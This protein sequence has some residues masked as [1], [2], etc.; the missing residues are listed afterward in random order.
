MTGHAPCPPFPLGTVVRFDYVN[1]RGER[2]TRTVRYLGMRFGATEWHPR[3]Q[4][5]IEGHDLDKNQPRVFALDDVE[6]GFAGM[7][8]VEYEANLLT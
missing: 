5:L 8:I 2:G 3:H 1:W 4:W 6:G 7:Q